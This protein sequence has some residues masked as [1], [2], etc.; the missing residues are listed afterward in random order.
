VEQRF[1]R[2]HAHHRVEGAE[3]VPV[4][5]H[6][7]REDLVARGALAPH[8]TDAGLAQGGDRLAVKDGHRGP[9]AD[10]HAIAPLRVERE[11]R[12]VLGEA[13]ADVGQVALRLLTYD[14]VGRRG[15]SD[16]LYDDFAAREGSDVELAL[17][18]PHVEAL[19][20]AR[21]QLGEALVDLAAQE[22]LGGLGRD[23]RHEQR[24]QQRGGVHRDDDAGRKALEGAAG[25]RAQRRPDLRG[26]APRSV[27]R[28]RPAP[29]R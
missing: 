13:V 29:R 8:G 11:E 25:H 26:P 1:D 18:V 21:Q 5:R 12:R 15:V 7:R 3:E 19:T 10:H 28:H 16:A 27:V 20:R 22:R 23:A 17:G 6:W 24:G 2:L 14:G 9:R 4:A